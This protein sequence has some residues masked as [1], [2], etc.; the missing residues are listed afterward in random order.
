MENSLAKRVAEFIRERDPFGDHFSEHDLAR[1]D[2]IGSQLVS[3][4]DAYA[5]GYEAGQVAARQH[6]GAYTHEY[7]SSLCQAR[8][9]DLLKL[10]EKLKR[11][12]APR[13]DNA[14][15]IREAEIEK[16]HCR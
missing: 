14:D 4:G 11:H 9:L 16:F 2:P 7:L 1:I 6:E 13:F 10:A 15:A 12:G 8:A 3:I 5:T